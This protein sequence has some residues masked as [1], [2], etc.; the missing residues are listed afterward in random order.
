MTDLDPLFSY[1]A[2]PG[3]T[4]AVHMT[5]VADVGQ[6]L[7]E[8]AGENPYGDD[9]S[10]VIET[11]AWT[12]DIGK[13]TEYFQTY[14]EHKTR[15]LAPTEELTYHGTFGG[16]VTAWALAVRGMSRQTT[17]AGFYAVAKHHSVLPNVRSDFADFC[18]DRPYVDQQYE[19]AQTQLDS[20]DDTA[21]EAADVVIRQAT[22]GAFG[23]DDYTAKGL[24]TVRTTLNDIRKSGLDAEFYGCALRAW[25]TLVAADKADASGLGDSPQLRTTRRPD[26]RALD[27]VVSS[28]SDTE[29]PDGTSASAY[30]DVPQRP[31]PDENWHYSDRLAALRTAANGRATSTL[32]ERHAAG[33][34]VFEL[35]LPTGFGKTFSGLRAGL[36]LADKL[37]SRVIYALPYTSIIDQVDEEV[38]KVFGVSP[39]NPEY[40]VHHH[41][42]DTRTSLSGTDDPSSGRDTLHAESWRSGLVLTT[43]TQLFES[44]AGPGNIQSMKL[45]AL[46]D[47]V[48]IVDEPQAISLDWWGLVG[49]VTQH[50]SEEYNATTVLMT[51]TQPRLLTHLPNAPTPT[52]LVDMHT[53]CT[54]LLRDAPR[55]QFDLHDSLTEYLDGTDAAPLSLV[56]AAEAIDTNLGSSTNELAIVNTVSCATA[57]SESLLDGRLALGSELLEYLR[58]TDGEEFDAAAYLQHLA[59]RHPDAE[60]VVAS[61]T[62]RLRPVDRRALLQCLDLILDDETTTPFDDVPTVTVSTQL[63]EAGVDLS[64]DRLYRDY[65]PLPSM[66]QAA[67]RCNRRFGGPTASVTVWRLDSPADDDYVPSQLIYGDRSL[68]R[69]SKV[70]LGELR[71]GDGSVIS[72]QDMLTTGV[73]TYYE[74]LHTQRDTADRADDLVTAFDRAQG[75][76]LRNE[77]VVSQDYPTQ[78]VFVLV[79][80]NDVEAHDAY[81]RHRKDEKWSSA[82]SAFHSLKPTL[83]SVPVDEESDEKTPLVI[84]VDE[85]SQN[86]DLET[87]GGVDLSGRIDAWEK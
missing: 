70:A 64:F 37:D 85:D 55:V 36:K 17:A 29:L 84:R 4:L 50:L 87:G 59:T 71:Y 33:D 16:F 35:T 27:A 66:V 48:I 15:R 10:A 81:A 11:L 5:G 6:Q 52:P 44:L 26:S 41:L 75:K 22:N 62:T 72:E 28:L 57:L 1:D 30:L 80:G 14:L 32:L 56:D 69:P 43:F 13:L 68:L 42:A 40:T 24:E 51:A 47:S 2:R 83:V 19:L 38:Q 65:G 63:I 49:R 86:Y 12:H 20:I 53:A 18:L 58:S 78:D 21:A 23:W 46:Q 79:S 7:V 76:K 34:R 31:L 61:L 82:R 74:A 9:W 25:S 45:P 67:G 54:G 8:N 39:L 60:G 73:E 3:Q 77:S